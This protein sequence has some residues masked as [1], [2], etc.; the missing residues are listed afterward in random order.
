MK[1]SI[2]VPVY[3]SEA[4]LDRCLQSLI[5]QDITDYEV[6]LVDDGSPDSCPQ[7]CDEWA[8]KDSHFRVVHKSNGGLSDARNAAIRVAQ[9]EWLTFVD[10]DDEVAPAS[11]AALLLLMGPDTDIIEYPIV[12]RHASGRDERLQLPCRTFSDARDYWLCTKG[13]THTY[14]CNKVYRKALFQHVTFPVGRVFEDAFTQPLLL[15]QSR[16]VT[17]T[18]EGCYIYHLNPQGITQQAQ[19][20]QLAMLLDAHLTTLRT[21]PD[22]EYYLHVVNIQMDVYELTG[23]QP[24]L[25]F[26]R[27]NPFTRGLSLKLRVKALLLNILGLRALCKLNK[28]LHRWNSNH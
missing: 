16:A 5:R 4:T 3:R 9:G 18:S 13:Y 2:I 12:R 22:A 27:V 28:T 20:P 23:Q 21:W 19:G 25:P 1:L 6:I 24:V 8:A 7:L 11:Y 14:A 15:Q 26:L 10:A 17:T